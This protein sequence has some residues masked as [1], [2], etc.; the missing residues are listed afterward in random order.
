VSQRLR[1]HLRE[2]QGSSLVETLLALMLLVLVVDVGV[3]GFAFAQARSVAIAAA[4]DGARAAASNGPSAGLD[5]AQRVLVAGGGAARELA[6]SIQETAG[7]VTV[8]VQGRAPAL[9]PITFLIPTIRT[10]ATLPLEQYQ[11]DERAT[12]P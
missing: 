2:E 5:Q 4:Q 7:S 6:P 12:N 10:S 11:P 1:K 8:T 3:E 9:F